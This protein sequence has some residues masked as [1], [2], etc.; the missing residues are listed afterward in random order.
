MNAVLDNFRT[1]RPDNCR[2]PRPALTKR[3]VEVVNAWVVADSKSD[4]GKSLFI[5]MGT[6]NT[7]VLRV[8]EKYRLLGRDAPTKTALLLRFLQDGFVTLEQL[9]GETPSAASDL[10]GPT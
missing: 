1:D 6:V 2:A 10:S 5:S 9:L 3:E 8:R 7:H 4:V